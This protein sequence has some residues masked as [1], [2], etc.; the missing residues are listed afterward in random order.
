MER[1]VAMA[2]ID[3]HLQGGPLEV[4]LD[5]FPSFVTLTLNGAGDRVS[6]YLRTV[7]DAKAVLAELATAIDAVTVPRVTILEEVK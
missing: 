4:R 7:A 1:G 2:N 3:I 5:Q 6:V